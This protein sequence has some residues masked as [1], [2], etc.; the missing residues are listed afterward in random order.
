MSKTQQSSSGT[1]QA[2]QS[3]QQQVRGS[4]SYFSQ[5]RS[6]PS[7]YGQ[8]SQQHQTAQYSTQQ[9]Q[10]Y[11]PQQQAQY[12]AQQSKQQGYI[13]QPQ[14]QYPSQQQQ[15]PSQQ[16]LQQ[17]SYA[18][19][20]AGASSQTLARQSPQ[21]GAATTSSY[22]P[23][24]ANFRSNMNTGLGF[25]NSTFGSR[26]TTA[27]TPANNSYQTSGAAAAYGSS[28]QQSSSY[29]ARTALPT[30]ASQRNPMQNVQNVQNLSQNMQEFHGFP[31]TTSLFDMSNLDS[32]NAGHSALNLG[33]A[34]YNMGAGN[35]PRT[36]G[37]PGSFGTPAMTNFDTNLGGND[38]YFGVGGRR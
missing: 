11:S 37:N 32:Q 21:F 2:Q 15:Y 14:Q 25:S 7:Q 1:N 10:T 18:T 12:P 24:D 30:S 19:T 5:N 26:R 3:Q 6:A 9:Q 36:S 8:Q 16:G 33:S 34:P 4:Q 29:G 28:G 31:D 22:N 23:G 38:R 17:Q 20:S 27:G 35:V 13:T